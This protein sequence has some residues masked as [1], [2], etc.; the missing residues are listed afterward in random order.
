MANESH[1][2]HVIVSDNVPRKGRVGKTESWKQINDHRDSNQLLKHGS[3]RTCRLTAWAGFT[4]ASGSTVY[5]AAPGPTSTAA[6]I[7]FASARQSGP[8]GPPDP[9]RRHLRGSKVR[10]EEFVAAPPL[11]SADRHADSARRL[12]HIADFYNQAVVHNDTRGPKHGPFNAAVRPT[13]TT[14]IGRI[15]RLQYKEP[16]AM[17]DADFSTSR[18][19]SIAFEHPNAGRPDPS[20]CSWSRAPAPKNSPRLLKSTSKPEAK[21]S[22]LDPQQLGKITEAELLR[23]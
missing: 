13:A 10:A 21:S 16:K 5:D 20:A 12:A 3:R 19:S 18:A 1:L 7:S 8:P 2:R 11:V 4:A 22:S 15:W 23:R 14:G 6:S 9:G 17:A